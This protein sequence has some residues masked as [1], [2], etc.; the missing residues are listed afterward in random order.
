MIIERVGFEKI[1]SLFLKG[2]IYRKH[3]KRAS[4]G[5]LLDRL[6]LPST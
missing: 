4:V 5:T 3:Q 6:D 1:M 2:V